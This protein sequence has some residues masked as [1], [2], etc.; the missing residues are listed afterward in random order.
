MLAIVDLEE[1]I[2]RDHPLWRIKAMANEALARLLPEFDRMYARVGRTLFDEVVWA[3]DEEGLLSDEHFSVDGTLIEAAASPG[4]SGPRKVRRCLQITIRATCPWTSAGSA[5]AT[6]LTLAPRIPEARLLCKGQGQEARL[7]FLG[8]ALMENHHG[9]QM[10]FTVNQVSGMAE[11]DAVPK[12]LDGVRARGYWSR[13]LGTDC[14][15][16]T[17]DCV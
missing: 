9:L 6:R 1:R 7:A 17:Q 12:L 15:Y 8:H 16:G 3:T 13:M 10:D 4:A 5:G 11:R 2:L 14:G